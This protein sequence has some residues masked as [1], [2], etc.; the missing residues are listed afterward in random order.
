VPKARR[1]S[2]AILPFV[3]ASDDPEMEYLSDGVTETII[4]ALSRIPKLRVM[5][6]STVFRFKGRLEDPQSIGRQLDVASVLVGR[7]FHRGNMLKIGVELVD[8][9]NGRQVWGEQYNRNIGDVFEVQDDIAKEISMKLEVKLTS[10]EKKSLYKRQT[11]NTDAYQL[12]LKGRF[13]WNKRTEDDIRTSIEF[14]TRAVGTDQSYALAYSGLAD[15]YTTQA[16]LCPHIRPRE[17][18]P[19]ARQAATKALSLDDSLAEAQASTGIIDLRYDWDTV[20]AELCFQRAI[21]LKPSYSIAHQWYGECLSAMTSFD[22]SVTQLKIAQ[23]LDP[24]SL[25]INSVLG[26]MLCFGRQYDQ[27][28]EQCLSTLEMHKD[29]WLALYFVGLAYECR[30]EVD[31]AI[32]AFQHAAT[33]AQRNPMVLAGLGHA[34]ASAGRRSEA[35]ALLDELR[36]LS[37]DAYTSPVNLALVALGLGEY[38]LAFTELDRAVDA[39]AGWLVFL[40][41]DPRFDCVRS[42]HRF[43]SL[44]RRVFDRPSGKQ[45][46]V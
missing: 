11:E 32:A 40:R 38:E 18:M 43:A 25:T 42:D 23:D 22:R 4:S 46:A 37:R 34:Y 7:V 35:K 20:S 27:S 15:S 6:H 33:A 30:G 28:I 41:A 5:A 19:Q 26:G 8:V 3:N 21:A 16:F 45:S 39:R 1:N 9:G 36:A 12:Y 10:E 14:F 24:L 2:I 31:K 13:F 44:L 17:L 29:F